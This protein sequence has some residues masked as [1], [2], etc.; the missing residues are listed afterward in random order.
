[1]KVHLNQI[2]A[3]G[4]HV[5]GVGS[6]RM[7][8][9]HEEVQAMLPESDKGARLVRALEA[10]RPAIAITDSWVATLPTEV[11]TYLANNYEGTTP[12]PALKKR[13]SELAKA[14]AQR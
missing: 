12:F 8:D 4:L 5:E 1:M 7:L 6:S 3:E 13:R 10:T 2:P 9:L 14:A 11:Q